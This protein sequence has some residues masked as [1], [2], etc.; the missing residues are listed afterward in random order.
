MRETKRH[1]AAFN[2]YFLLRPRR[3]I[4]ALRDRLAA[5]PEILGSDRVPGLRTLYRWSTEFHWQ[6]RWSTSSAKPAPTISRSTSRRFV[7]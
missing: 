4:E 5:D 6:D 3:S 2:E 7:S 1:R